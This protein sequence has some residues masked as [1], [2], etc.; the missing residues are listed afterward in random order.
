MAV[1]FG[2]LHK[3]TDISD[4]RDFVESDCTFLSS[5]LQYKS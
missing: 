3:K 5:M 4:Q 2:I 1:A